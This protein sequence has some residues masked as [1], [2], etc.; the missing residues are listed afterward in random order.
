MN[1]EDHIEMMKAVQPFIDTSISKTVNVAS[2]Y[3]YEKFKN[4]YTQAWDARLKGLAT[5]RPNSILGS[6]LEVKTEE[7]ALADTKSTDTSPPPDT[8][9]DPMRAVIE[10]RPLGALEAVAEKIEYWTSEGVKS[11][12]L[13]VSFLPLSRGEG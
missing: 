5:Y 12:Y 13:I 11:F 3:P 6:V 1:A 7:F 8:M 10:K 9:P 4:L 2:D